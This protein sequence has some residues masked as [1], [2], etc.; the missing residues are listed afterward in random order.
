MMFWRTS[1]PLEAIV[2]DAN[3]LLS[4]CGV[5]CY[6]TARLLKILDI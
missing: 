5:P 1:V 4:I 3:V 2:A 6:S